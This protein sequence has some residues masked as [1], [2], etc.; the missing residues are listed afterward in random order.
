MREKQAKTNLIIGLLVDNPNTGFSY[1]EIAQKIKATPNN[2][3]NMCRYILTEAVNSYC[4]ET[5]QD[6]GE[7]KEL[8][9][10][11][12]YNKNKAISCINRN[13]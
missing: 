3:R 6:W 11:I 9:Y 8:V 1:K 13:H 7:R 2:V 5:Y 12:F 10:K 4:L